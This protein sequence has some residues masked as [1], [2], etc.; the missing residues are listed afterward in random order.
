VEKSGKPAVD[1]SANPIMTGVDVKMFR[2]TFAVGCLERGL[3]KDDVAR[4]LGHVNTD[5]IDKHYAPWVKALDEALIRRAE[6]VMAQAQP[7]KNMRIVANKGVRVA[8]APR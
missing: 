7:N 4:Y 3:P 8:A 1:R 6:Q 2:H 5:M